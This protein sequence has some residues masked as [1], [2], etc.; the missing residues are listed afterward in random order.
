LFQL[1]FQGGEIRQGHEHKKR[2]Y[3]LCQSPLQ[4]DAKYNGTAQPST[5]TQPV[6]HVNGPGLEGR[7]RKSEEISFKKKYV[8]G[9]ERKKWGREIKSLAQ[10]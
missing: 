3:G 1:I 4:W 6:W 5:H 10:V 7:R 9:E 8:G 2:R